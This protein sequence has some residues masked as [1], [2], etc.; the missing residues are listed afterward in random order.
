MVKAIDGADKVQLRELLRNLVQ[1]IDI[2]RQANTIK[3]SIFFYS[4]INAYSLGHRWRRHPAIWS[5]EAAE[6]NDSIGML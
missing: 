6:L 1:R 5:G 3:G 4:P 2:K